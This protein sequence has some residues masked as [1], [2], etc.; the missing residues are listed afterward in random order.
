MLVVQPLGLDG[1]DE[2]LGPVG[3]GA[4]VGHA[5]QAGATVLHQEV[6]VIELGTVNALAAC[7]VKILKISTLKTEFTQSLMGF[8]LI[9][10]FISFV[11]FRPDCKEHLYS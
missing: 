1:R 6:L 7:P 9:S 2:E 3:V 8:Y 11:Q 4:G 10:H 5:Q